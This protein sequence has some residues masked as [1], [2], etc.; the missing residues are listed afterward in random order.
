MSYNYC[1]HLSTE[2]FLFYPLYISFPKFPKA[3]LTEFESTLLARRRQIDS[4]QCLKMPPP[5][6]IQSFARSWPH[7]PRLASKSAHVASLVLL[8][9]CNVDRSVVYLPAPIHTLLL[10]SEILSLSLI[11]YRCEV[12]ALTRKETH[13]L[14]SQLKVKSLMSMP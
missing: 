2:L 7:S 10:R 9:A 8:F 1:N 12:H 6:L 14:W 13:C 5:S 3:E 4:W 11:T